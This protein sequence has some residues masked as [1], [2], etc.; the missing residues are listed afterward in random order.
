MSALGDG[1]VGY[2]MA[3]ESFS[4]NVAFMVRLLNSLLI[5]FCQLLALVIILS[6]VVRALLVYVNDGLLKG[7][8]AEAFQNS[9]LSMSYAFSLGLSFLIGASILKTMISSQW[10]DFVRLCAIIGVRTILNLLLERS[11]QQGKAVSLG[12]AIASEQSAGS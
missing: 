5:S 4:Q 8:T 2:F 9:R 10:D 6:G 3:L 1:L 11:I 7:A 12:A